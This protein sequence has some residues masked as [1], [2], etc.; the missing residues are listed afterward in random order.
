MLIKNRKGF[1]LTELLVTLA[2]IGLFSPLV[3]VIFVSGI[4]DFSTTTKYMGQQYSVMEVTSLLRQDIEEAKIITLSIS[5]YPNKL[6]DEITFEFD[7]TS[8]RLKRQWKF[9]TITDPTTGEVINGLWLNVDGAGYKCV[10]DELEV[11][12]CSFKVDKID[13][14]DTSIKP[15]RLILSIKPESLNKSRYKGR[16]VNENIITEFS[17]RYKEIFLP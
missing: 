11:S 12:Q 5:D 8:S 1:S 16:N 15:E 10:V 13:A 14:V 17:V 9:D 4:E 2:I 6:V 3:F 7:P